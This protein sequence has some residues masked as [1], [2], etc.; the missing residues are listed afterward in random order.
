MGDGCAVRVTA[1]V[2]QSGDRQGPQQLSVQCGA[3]HARAHKEGFSV[4]HPV[5]TES[6]P[7]TATGTF[8]PSA[9][10]CHPPTRR[11]SPTSPVKFQ[12]SEKTTL[13]V[14]GSA[15]GG[16]GLVSSDGMSRSLLVLGGLLVGL[17]DA[18]RGGGGCRPRRPPA[19]GDRCEGGFRLL[20]GLGC[21][22]LSTFHA[23]VLG[24][25]LMM[26]PAT[27]ARGRWNENGRV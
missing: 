25:T 6:Y 22:D 14:G 9:R 3:S 7:T 11:H 8:T 12:S 5:T 20:E 27:R 15:G 4:P 26:L 13:S 19:V 17:G 23:C 24:S 1:R 10:A 18:A 2:P 16:G 21:P